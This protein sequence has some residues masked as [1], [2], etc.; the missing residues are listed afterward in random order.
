MGVRRA[1]RC[2]API[3]FRRHRTAAGP[4]AQNRL[5]HANQLASELP[6]KPPAAFTSQGAPTE[7]FAVPE[8]PLWLAGRT[9]SKGKP[10]ESIFL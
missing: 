2:D 7:N 3:D 1:P 10:W 6:S 5:G 4:I 9:A 8:S